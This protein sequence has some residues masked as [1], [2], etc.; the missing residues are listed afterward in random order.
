MK[1][2]FKKIKT[3]LKISL[4]YVTSVEFWTIYILNFFILH[5]IALLFWVIETPGNKQ[6][7]SHWDTFVW[8]LSTAVGGGGRFTPTTTIGTALELFTMTYGVVVIAVFTGLFFNFLT[9]NEKFQKEFT[10][11]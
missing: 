1:N 3:L 4:D 2:L 5:G 10:G 11:K 6:I 7:D 8:A 9:E